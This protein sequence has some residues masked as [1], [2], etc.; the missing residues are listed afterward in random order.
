MFLPNSTLTYC[1]PFIHDT[2]AIS[3]L[4]STLSN[5]V[6]FSICTFSDA[7]CNHGAGGY[8]KAN[9]DC[10]CNYNRYG[11]AACTCDAV[12]CGELDRKCVDSKVRTSPPEIPVRVHMCNTNNS[13]TQHKTFE[14][15]SVLGLLAFFFSLHLHK[16]VVCPSGTVLPKSHAIVRRFQLHRRSLWRRNGR[17]GLVQ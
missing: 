12:F 8:C 15:C 11:S 9:H 13:H 3:Y 1:F 4:L 7:D 5:P 14:W 17:L 2:P 10:Q 6:K 16:P